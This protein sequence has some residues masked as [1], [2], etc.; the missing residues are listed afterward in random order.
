M[1]DPEALFTQI[2][3]Q[4]TD[5][6]EVKAGKMFG[7]PTL[8]VNGKAFA[9]FHHG[10]MVFKLEGETHA[11]ALSLEGAGLFDPAGRGRP[12]REWVRLPAIHADEWSALA[13]EACEYVAR[14]K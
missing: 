1:P 3:N 12:M 5:R 13:I 9:G 7:M 6:P 8:T 14:I 4:M 2:V 11:R 10:D